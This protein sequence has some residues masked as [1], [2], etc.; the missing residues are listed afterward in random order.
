MAA[1]ILVEEGNAADLEADVARVGLEA[2][3]LEMPPSV[4]QLAHVNQR[5]ILHLVPFALAPEA[6]ITQLLVGPIPWTVNG[7]LNMADVPGIES[8]HGRGEVVGDVTTE[9]AIG[10]C[11]HQA[12]SRL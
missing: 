12:A 11:V 5:A 1:A 8:G 9:A 3:L 2:V 4:T 6:L 7:G 10:V